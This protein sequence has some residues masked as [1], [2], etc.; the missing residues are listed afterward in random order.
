MMQVLWMFPAPVAMPKFV[1]TSN[2]GKFR[3]Q[4]LEM[5]RPA[6]AVPLHALHRKHAHMIE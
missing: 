3:K 5:A 6:R 2:D 1:M 4:R